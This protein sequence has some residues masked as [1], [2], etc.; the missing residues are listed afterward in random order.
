MRMN[1]MTEKYEDVTVLGRPMLFTS[2]RV[3]RDTVPRGLYVYEVRHDDDCQG[4]PV[5]IGKGIMVNCWG[6]IISNTPIRL[7]PSLYTNNAYRD[8]DPE[9]DWKYDGT[10][11]TLKEYMEKHPPVIKREK[12]Q[13]YER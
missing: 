8:I 9:K 3:D 13:E 7:K 1:A 2:A 6:T 4:Y 10:V 5:Q 12:E 11:S